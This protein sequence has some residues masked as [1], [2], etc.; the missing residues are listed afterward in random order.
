MSNEVRVS[1]L[2]ATGSVGKATRD[3]ILT[4]TPHA[5]NFR[6]KALTAHS[7]VDDLVAAAIKHKAELAA[8]ACQELYPALKEALAGTGVR[9]AA[10]SEGILEAASLDADIVV[11]AIVGIAGLRPTLAALANGS[12]VALANKESMVCAGQL[13]NSV[14]AQSGARLLPIDSEH[15]AIFQVLDRPERV[16]KITLTASGGPFRCSSMEE[17]RTATRETALRHPNWSMGAKISIDSATMMNKGLELIEAAYLFDVD[18]SQ[19]DVVVHPQS[20]IHSLVNYDDGSVLAQMGQP[21]MRIPI[22]YALAWPTRM[23]QPSVGRL[24]LAKIG[25]LDFEAPDFVKFPALDL[26]RQAIKTEGTAPIV[27]NAANEIGVE[28][29]LQ[30]HIDFLSITNTVADMLNSLA[31]A[32]QAPTRLEDILEVDTQARNATMEKLDL[33]SRN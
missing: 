32:G 29:F 17:M 16:E 13:L 2:G 1:I 25:R 28:A 26:A 19:V 12:S 33:R 9:V 22:S 5:P 24:D 7:N 8:I 21:D 4:D 23:K 3:V 11:V 15:N 18:Q 30:G 20:I 31:V 6:V 27:L 10:G 14:A